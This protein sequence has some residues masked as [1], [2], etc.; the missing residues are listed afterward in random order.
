MLLENRRSMW[1]SAHPKGRNQVPINSELWYILRSQRNTGPGQQTPL[2]AALKSGAMMGRTTTAIMPTI[3]GTWLSFCRNSYFTTHDCLP[4]PCS[5]PTAT[6][7]GAG[8]AA[9]HNRQKHAAPQLA[10]VAKTRPQPTGLRRALLL[11]SHRN[12]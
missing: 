10:R 2:E 3:T 12:V 6:N 7:S 11:P 1:E 8:T 5:K 9:A 4:Q